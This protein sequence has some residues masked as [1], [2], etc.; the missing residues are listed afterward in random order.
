MRFTR[1]QLEL[2]TMTGLAMVER[3]LAPANESVRAGLQVQIRL[4]SHW[5]DDIHDRR[6]TRARVPGFRKLSHFDVF[7]PNPEQDWFAQKLTRLRSI[8][9]SYLDCSTLHFLEHDGVAFL[10]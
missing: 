6:K 9:E 4:R 2:Q 7:R 8:G 5:F 1:M 3:L 10:F